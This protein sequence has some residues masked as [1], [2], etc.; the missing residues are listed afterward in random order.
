MPLRAQQGFT[1]PVFKLADISL[2]YPHYTSISRR[3]KEVE[4]TVWLSQAFTLR[5]SH[6]SIEAVARWETK[7]EKLQC[8]GW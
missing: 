8:S 4:K 7:P 3:A 2:V 5:N 1:D 6:V